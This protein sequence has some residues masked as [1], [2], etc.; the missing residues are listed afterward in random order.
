MLMIGE[1][2]MRLDNF[3]TTNV[4]HAVNNQQFVVFAFTEELVHHYWRIEDETKVK[5]KVLEIV[6]KID[7]T[8]TLDLIKG[9][10]V[11]GL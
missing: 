8:I 10:G 11:N 5:Y 4:L 3:V 9:W 1:N 2:G 7:K 6:Q